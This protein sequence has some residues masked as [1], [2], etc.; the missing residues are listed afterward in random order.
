MAAPLSDEDIKNVA[1]FY[2]SKQAK[3]GFSKNKD[4]VKLGEKIYRG[5]IAE[6]PQRLDFDKHHSIDRLRAHHLLSIERHQIAQIHARW[7]RK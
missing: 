3:P 2:A 5:G 7:K 6:A 4:T 1:A